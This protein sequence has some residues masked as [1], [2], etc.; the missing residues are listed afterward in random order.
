MKKKKFLG[1]WDGWCG[2]GSGSDFE[3]NREG[4]NMRNR[5][6]Q[7]IKVATREVGECWE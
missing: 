1:L 4:L 7:A 2:P 5:M 3:G 6:L